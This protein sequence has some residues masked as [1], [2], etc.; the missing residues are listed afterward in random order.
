MKQKIGL[1]GGSFNP[2]HC[3]HVFMAR[4]FVD[5][6]KL[7]KCL[8]IPAAVS[9]FKTEDDYTDFSNEERLAMARALTNIKEEFEVWDFEI[10]KG[11]T[12]YTVETVTE[13][14]R[15]YPDAELFWLFGKDHVAGFKKWKSPEKILECVTLAIV[16]RD[17]E[18]SADD[19]A[20]LDAT[21]GER[22]YIILDA[23]LIEISSTEVR[24]KL[25]NLDE[26]R[27]I[28]PI[29]ILPFLEGKSG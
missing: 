20:F 9:P 23:P 26:L 19:I 1:F 5:T 6:L 22:N 21:I 12:S 27:K 18:I 7:D 28:V 2:P 4:I 29:E 10:E 8:F 24:S 17:D 25:G 13:A 16:N 15:L 11:G 3:G 14:K